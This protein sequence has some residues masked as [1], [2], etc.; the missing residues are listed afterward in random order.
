MGLSSKIRWQWQYS[1]LQ[2]AIGYSWRSSGWRSDYNETFALVAKMTTSIRIFL[3]VVAVKGWEP[4]QMDVNNVFLHGD[5]EEE[6]YMKLPPGFKSNDPTK[7]CRLKKSLYGLWH[8][9]Q[10]WFAKLSTKLCEN[11]FVCWL[12]PIRLSEMGSVHVTTCLCGRH[13][14]GK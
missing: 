12:L 9:I 1:V 5:L 3:S 8:P 4:H 2:G 10:Q 7:V 6:V 13:N 14:A 11:R